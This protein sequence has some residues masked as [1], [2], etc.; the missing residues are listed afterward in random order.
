MLHDALFATAQRLPDAV[1]LECSEERLSYAQLAGDVRRIAD[2]L[3][4]Q[5]VGGGDRVAVIGEKSVRMVAA[6]YAVMAC[7]ASYVPVDAN[8]PPERRRAVLRHASLAA[9]AGDA[10]AVSSCLGDPALA[11]V[12][13]IAV[14]PGGDCTVLAGRAQLP[15]T[16]PAS[17]AGESSAYVLYTSGSTGEP[18]G[19]EHS[20]DSALAFAR[21]A[22]REFSLQP[23]DRLG[24]HA[25]LHFDLTTF[26]LFS[27]MLSGAA[28]VLVPATLTIFPSRVAEY[29]AT[30]RLTT[31]YSVPTAL[32]DMVT[33][34]GFSARSA[35]AMQRILF[36]GERYPVASLRKLRAAFPDA[37]LCNLFGP[38][39][40]N[41]C[42]Y[43]DVRD[44]DLADDGPPLPIGRPCPYA[45]VR[46]VDD[47]GADAAPGTAGQLWVRSDT[48]MRGYLHDEARSAQ[49]IAIDA[50]G[51][52][53]L[54]T[55]D[56]VLR[57]GD[58][59]LRF[60]GR[61]DRQVKIRGVRIELDAIEAALAS[62][63]RVA[64]AAVWLRPGGDGGTAEIHATVALDAPCK[65]DERMLAMHLGRHLP[66]Q[67]IPSHMQLRTGLPLNANGKLDRARIERESAQVA[68][69]SVERT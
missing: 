55:G 63:P 19:V 4:S 68:D 9:V 30:K 15:T 65:D 2:T 48:N 7:G 56:R 58:G 33:R 3:R 37:R 16:A 14:G 54:R 41:V 34:G 64:A 20:H 36:A 27:A 62:H 11:G 12:A 60:L 26:D 67:A 57:D 35:P 59:L 51:A 50:Q 40:T 22:A 31:W 39:E 23:D 10:Q 13:G 49:T 61:M 44:I 46:L 29:A 38:T 52:H 5:G 66:P 25:P 32:A 69:R 24:S 17:G 6:L 18:K 45:V 1:A 43:H 53:W 47:G 8:A 28:C 42:T 21:W